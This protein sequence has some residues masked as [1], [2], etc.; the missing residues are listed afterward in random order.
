M[1][2]RI[3]GELNADLLDRL[4]GD[5][6]DRAADKVVLLLTVDEAG[7]PHA[8]FLSYFEVVAIDARNLRLATYSRSTTT[9]N[10]R[11][12]GKVTAA[13]IDEGVACY[14]KGTATEL[15]AS[16]AAAPENAKHNVRVEQVLVDGPDPRFEPGASITSGV[17]YRRAA[18]AAQAERA[19]RLLD[20]LRA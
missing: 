2:T 10:M 7:W 18:A 5:A 12:S 6:R 8:A 13:I 19:M 14:I 4:S 3:G 11:R 17:T 1:T 16:M 15:S 20:E 9:G